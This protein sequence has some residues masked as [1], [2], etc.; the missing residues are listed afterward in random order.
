MST[1]LRVSRSIVSNRLNQFARLYDPGDEPEPEVSPRPIPKRIKDDEKRL[2]SV[3]IK[4]LGKRQFPLYRSLR[5]QKYPHCSYCGC[6]LTEE[7]SSLDHVLPQSKGGDNWPAN[8]RLSCLQCNG[9]KSSLTLAEWLARTKQDIR[10]A[11]A[12]LANL[13]ELI[14]SGLEESLPD[15]V[16]V[17]KSKK[18]KAMSA[19]AHGPLNGPVIHPNGQIGWYPEIFFQGKRTYFI[20]EKSSSKPLLQNLGIQQASHYLEAVGGEGLELFMLT[21]MYRNELGLLQNLD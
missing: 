15:P 19:K 17:R 20:R 2:V 9:E 11:R 8:L 16:V 3:P 21:P 12:L 1:A 6:D 5:V 10:R 7:T 13:R 18:R 4:P 14:D